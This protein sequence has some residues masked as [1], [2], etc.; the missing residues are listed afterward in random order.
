MNR[1]LP[2]SISIPDAF[3]TD[4]ATIYELSETYD[5]YGQR[6]NSSV[7][8]Y[9]DIPAIY[10]TTID[11]VYKTFGLYKEYMESERGRGY[12]FLKGLLD[13]LTYGCKVDILRQVGSSDDVFVFGEWRISSIMHPALGKFMLCGLEHIS[14]MARR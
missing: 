12:I 13:N 9:E 11:T 1:K 8:I 14:G 2:N 5:E 10:G 6:V 7:P 3:F 4:R